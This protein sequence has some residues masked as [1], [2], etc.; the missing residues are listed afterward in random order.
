MAPPPL[1]LLLLLGAVLLQA[2]LQP[3]SAFVSGRPVHRARLVGIPRHHHPLRLTPL[4]ATDTPV[5]ASSL[6][7]G[8]RGLA[9]LL[10]GIR[11]LLRPQGQT[12]G[13]EIFT[14]TW[15]IELGHTDSAIDDHESGAIHVSPLFSVGRFD[16][17]LV[18]AAC[19]GPDPSLGLYLEHFPSFTLAAVPSVACRFRW[20][21]VSKGEMAFD[22]TF[23][24]PLASSMLAGK[25]NLIP[26]PSHSHR[27]SEPCDSAA[28]VCVEA[29]VSLLGVHFPGPTERG[30]LEAAAWERLLHQVQ[31]E[32]E[33]ESVG[34]GGELE[35]EDMRLFGR[36][37]G[38]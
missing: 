4:A 36:E 26:L 13:A 14:T 33:E 24:D 16:F 7:S 10:N 32:G 6:R 1:L 27:S 18:A 25:A 19:V 28:V 30:A 11:G 22:H 29:T 38:D 21:Q 23:K 8:P 37:G 2:C 17:R 15:T 12:P 20:S 35:A 5:P 9:R 34:A 31:G 3:A